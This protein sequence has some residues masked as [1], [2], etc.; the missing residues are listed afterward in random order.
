MLLSQLAEL[1]K[2]VEAVK[3]QLRVSVTETVVPPQAPVP[4][5]AP[6]P[7]TT[8]PAA[9]M[10]KRHLVVHLDGDREMYRLSAHVL[11]EA[12]QVIKDLSC[13][14]PERQ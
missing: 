7:L 13:V 12:L 14:S 6:P 3:E 10:P 1:Q 2:S 11:A 5:I 8:P 4:V 9:E